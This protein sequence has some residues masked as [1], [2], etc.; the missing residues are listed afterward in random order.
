VK[1][2]VAGCCTKCDAEVYEVRQRDPKT[3]L[4]RRLGAALP[5]AR[6]ATFVL[7]NG[8]RMDLTFCSD[9]ASGLVPSE[10]AQLWQRVMLSWW[11]ERNG[12]EWA[13]T[14]LNNGIAGL[15][16]TRNVKEAA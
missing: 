14:Q 16:G 1:P 10:Y 7:M 6:R 11:S 5:N 8:T 13:K 4:P 2:K 9:C 3:K 15:L 12:S